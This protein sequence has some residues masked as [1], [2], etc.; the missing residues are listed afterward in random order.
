MMPSEY[1]TLVETGFVG[2]LKR[3]V[4]LEASRDLEFVEHILHEFT[5]A[6]EAGRHTRIACA[7]R[8]VEDLTG[9]G[10][11]RLATWSSTPEE[12]HEPRDKNHAE[13]LT[14]FESLATSQENR[15]AYFLVTTQLGDAWVDRYLRLVGEL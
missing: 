15:N 6:G 4:L 7:A 10:L 12:G 8:L 3:D 11:C 5:N 9:S 1:D 2:S 13:L 14:L